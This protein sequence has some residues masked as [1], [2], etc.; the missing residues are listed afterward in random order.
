M[1][2]GRSVQEA[3]GRA[4]P[5]TPFR[6]HVGMVPGGGPELL[7]PLDPPGRARAQPGPGLC[8]R[9]IGTRLA[10]QKCGQSRF[11]SR[12]ADK[13]WGLGLGSDTECIWWGWRVEG[14]GPGRWKESEAPYLQPRPAVGREERTPTLG[15]RNLRGLPGLP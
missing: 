15:T 5:S 6:L 9:D 3:P 14:Q 7:P 4:S 11:Q 13:V 8:Q 1:G 10:H 12:P 2:S